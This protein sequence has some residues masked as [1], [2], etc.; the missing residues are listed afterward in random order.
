MQKHWIFVII[1]SPQTTKKEKKENKWVAYYHVLNNWMKLKE[2][3]RSVEQ[4]LKEMG[5]KSVSIY[6]MG[7]IGKQLVK[8]LENTDIE[9]K[10]AIDRS[11]LQLVILIYMNRK[12]NCRMLMQLL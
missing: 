9:V 1:E 12:A 8:D 6:G 3:G 4:R 7:D 2:N 5:I 10:Y 11:F